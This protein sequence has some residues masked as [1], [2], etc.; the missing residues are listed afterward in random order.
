[1]ALLVMDPGLA[2]A[3]G[4]G[5]AQYLLVALAL[6]SSL[7]TPVAIVAILGF[8]ILTLLGFDVSSRVM[9]WTATAKLA[10]V[11]VLVL[12]GAWRAGHGSSSVLSDAPL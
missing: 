11:G 1:M 4:I 10:G 5:L 7:V 9:R 12:A 6:P 8:G 3:L 2:A